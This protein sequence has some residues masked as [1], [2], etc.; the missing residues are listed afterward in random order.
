MALLVWPRAR[1]S[2]TCPRSTKAMITAAGS[3]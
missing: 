3:K 1:S 2:N